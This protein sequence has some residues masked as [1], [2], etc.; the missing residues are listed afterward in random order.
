MV[1]GIAILTLLFITNPIELSSILSK[2]GLKS[3]SLIPALMWKVVPHLM[4]SAEESL[5]VIKLKKDQIW[6]GIANTMVAGL[7]YSEFYDEGLF[8][9]EDIFNPI[10]KYS[11]KAIALYIILLVVNLIIYCISTYILII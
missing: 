4:K 10:F 5:L 7:E 6:K 2:L 3:I 8:L 11:P 9:K 1:V